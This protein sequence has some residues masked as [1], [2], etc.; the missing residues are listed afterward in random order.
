MTATDY[1]PFGMQ[2]PGRNGHAVIIGN[3][4][5]DGTTNNIINDLTVN[6]RSGNNPSIYSA[7]NSITFMDGFATETSDGFET[8]LGNSPPT[9][10]GSNSANWSSGSSTYRY[11][12][13]GKENDKEVKG[14]GNTYD[15]GAR[16]YDPRIG[17]TPSLDPEKHLY[18]EI[19]PYVYAIDNPVNV[20]DPDGK[21]IIFINGMQDGFQGGT[22]KY[23]AGVDT[24]IINRIGDHHT[25]YRDGSMGGVFEVNGNSSLSNTS[26]KQR[27]IAGYDQGVTDAKRIIAGLKKD[28]NDPNKIIETVKIVTHSMGTAYSRGYT[29]ALE[30]Y[31]EDYNKTH[32]ETPILGFRIETQVDIAGFQGNQLPVT[33]KVD[34]KLFMSGDADGVANGKGVGALRTISSGSDVPDSKQIPTDA[35]TGHGIDGFGKDKYMLPIPVSTNNGDEP[36]PIQPYIRPTNVPDAS[37]TKSIIVQ[38]LNHN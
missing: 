20:V 34:N 23:W 35:G 14:E 12:F 36:V 7:V 37:A 27:I 22:K 30:K 32:I 21:L 13:N 18:T 3:I 1:Y 28:P 10:S 19:S 9:G 15:L 16:L 31:V 25:M 11:G 33:S 5:P 38:P 8:V 17:R 6:S 26:A 2:L 24:K 4:N 29:I